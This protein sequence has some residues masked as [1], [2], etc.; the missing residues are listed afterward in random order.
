MKKMNLSELFLLTELKRKMSYKLQNVMSFEFNIVKNIYELTRL[1]QLKENH[2]KRIDDVKTRRRFD[3]VIDEVIIAEARTRAIII[4]FI[5]S[6]TTTSI[7]DKSFQISFE[8]N[9][10]SSTS[11]STNLRTSN[12][13]S[14]REILMK[15]NR[16]FNCF[17][18]D[19]ISKNCFKSKKFRVAKMTMN[20]KN[21][22]KD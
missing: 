18:I 11:R 15:K 9:L 16:C 19:H 7:N 10:Y 6:T 14:T 22:K 4:K 5:S 1:T 17:E 13:D 12:F 21:S 20:E 3:A 8:R 2:Y